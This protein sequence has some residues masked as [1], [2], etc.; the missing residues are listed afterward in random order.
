S[1]SSPARI[2]TRRREARMRMGMIGLGRMGG[3]M[4]R[5]LARGGIDVVA[6]DRSPAAR[7]A[8]GDEPRIR[9]ADDLAA[10][11][12]SLDAPR[13]LWLMLPAGAP[14]EETLATLLPLMTAG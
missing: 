2:P 1:I 5:R 13:V 10:L 3:N 7:E 4:A 12:A 8:L 6:F 9:G 11:V 14:T